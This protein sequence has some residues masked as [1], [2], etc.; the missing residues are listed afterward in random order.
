MASSTAS[1]QGVNAVIN[2]LRWEE[3][4][5]RVLAGTAIADGDGA[6]SFGGVFLFQLKKR[7]GLGGSKGKGPRWR[8]DGFVSTKP[9]M[10]C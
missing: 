1:V 6:L 5:G 2:A 7:L 10:K 9:I 3:D 4:E 8:G